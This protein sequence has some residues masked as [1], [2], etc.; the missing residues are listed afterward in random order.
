MFRVRAVHL[1]SVVVSVVL[2]SGGARAQSE[3]G[4][5]VDVPPGDE[6]SDTDPSALTD[7]RPA[8]DPYGAWVDDP[9]YGT[10][11]TPD[12]NQVGADFAPYDS[13]GQWGYVGNDYT[14]VSDYAWG[15]VA[16]HYGRWV[17]AGG[18]WLWIPGR[19]YSPAWVDWRVGD[20]GML[21]WAPV[22]PAWSWNGGNAFGIGFQSPEPWSFTTFGDV[23]GIG[24]VNRVTSGN[25]ALG[26]LG[27]SRAYV[28]AQPTPPGNPLFQ[29]I[30]HGPPPASL[31]IDVSRIPH[32]VLSGN[33][34]RARQL[35]HPSTA[36]AMGA[37]PPTPH[38]IRSRPPMQ[39]GAPAPSRSGV[40]G[41]R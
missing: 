18:R 40:R 12:G 6:Y 17:L 25:A 34:L 22:A 39:R 16:F 1:S 11:W 14:W 9:S 7:F 10:A 27:H 26:I 8:L 13:A 4:V 37:R 31:G 20:D 29:A 3:D 38:V 19:L 21:G 36:V 30:M 28:R 32:L 35:A 24:L 2:W 15:W 5:P 33:E 23:F 41:R